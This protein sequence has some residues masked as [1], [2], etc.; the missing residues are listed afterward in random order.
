MVREPPTADLGARVDIVRAIAAARLEDRGP[1]M[2]ILHDVMAEFGY[3]D[4][5]DVIA[6]AEVLN[7]SV[8]DVHGVVSFYKDFRTAPVP[9]HIVALCRGEACQAVGA[10]TLYAAAR[11]A[12]AAGDYGPDTEVEHVFCFG[13]CALGPSGTVDGRLVGR[14]DPDRLSALTQDWL[15]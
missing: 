9:S 15:P 14:L 3:I 12:A 5:A 13:N 4:R 6:I 11:D 7:L 2:P 10:E 1:L 8:A